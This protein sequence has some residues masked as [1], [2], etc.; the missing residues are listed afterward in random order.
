M[1]PYILAL[2]QGTTSS[3]A[4]LFDGSGAIVGIA[5]QEFEQIYPQ[6]GWVEHDPESIWGSQLTTARRV[7]NETGVRPIEVAV[8]GITNQRETTLLW[9][10]ASGRPV[11]NAIVWQDRR[12]TPLCERLRSEGLEPVIRK[13]TG[14]ILDP[15]FS[16]T[17]LVWMLE[18][19]PGIRQRAER[20]ELAFGTVDTFLLWRLTNGGVHATDVSNASRTMLFNLQTLDWDEELLQI[21]KIPRALLPVV[22]P[23][24]HA[25]GETVSEHL[26]T[27]IPVGG[28][29]GDQQAAAFGQTCFQAGMVKNTYGTGSFLLLNTGTVPQESQHGLISTAGWQLTGS[30]ACYALE[31]SIFITGAAIQWLRDELG[32]IRNASET[33][34]LAQ[35]VTDTGGVFFVPAFV[36]LGAPYWDSEARGLV[37]GITRGTNRAHL[38]RAA[39]EAAAYQTRDVLEAMQADS[40][41]KIPD[42]RVDG[43]MT[44]NRFLLQFQADILGV[45]VHKPLIT[46]TTALGA[47]YLAGLSGGIWHNLPDIAALWRIEQ[48]YESQMSIDRR[49]C[50]YEGWKRAVRRASTLYADENR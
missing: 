10:R 11:M 47:A 35:S 17:K 31:G 5:Q 25:F 40:G 6:P 43:G 28:M 26:G 19:L 34:S 13:K 49:E 33:E 50:L 30:Q 12:T 14:L 16:A 1:K 21:F 45:P 24:T 18:N 38:A 7:L 39:L 29:A 2:D 22:C 3:R 37:S 27:S 32:I 8:V 44:A 36:G 15:Y 46:E 42:L 20:G 4:I 23:S 9:E 48:T 41:T